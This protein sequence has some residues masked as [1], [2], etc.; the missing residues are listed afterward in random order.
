MLVLD[1]SAL[2]GIAALIGSVA[3]LVWAIRRKA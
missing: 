3:T 1:P 2:F